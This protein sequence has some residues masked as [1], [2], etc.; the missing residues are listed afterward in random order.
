MARNPFEQLQ[1]VVPEPRQ[2]FEDIAALILRAT[3]SGSRRVRV[4]KGDGGVDTYTGTYGEDGHADVYQIKYFPSVWDESRK[5]QIRESYRTARDNNDFNLGTWTLCVPTRLTKG[6]LR[7]FDEWKTKQDRSIELL[8]GD[9]ITERL[10]REECGQARQL[11]RS[12]GLI[13]LA[14]GG[15]RIGARAIFRHEN[16][17]RS[18]LTAVLV[19]QLRN[20][21]DR[22]ARNLKLIVTHGETGCL[23]HQATADWRQAIN[24]GCV[25]PRRLYYI[26]TL[27]PG[28]RSVVMGI[29]VCDRTE[30]PLA[31]SLNITAEDSI[32]SELTCLVDGS[33]LTT[34]A[35]VEFGTS[36]SLISTIAK[37]TPPRVA[38][39]NPPTSPAA[40]DLLETILAH[41]TPEER[42]LTQ[43]LRQWPGGVSDQGFIPNTT[44][45]GSA[46][47]MKKQVLQTAIAELVQLGWL[48]KPEGDDNVRVYA[49]VTDEGLQPSLR[50]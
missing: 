33:N 18:G 3:V 27:N 38:Q 6:D 12:W 22:S 11:L 41:P 10:Q 36:K 5:Q 37:S 34:G 2:A 16:P 43:I 29:P 7:W 44:E 13:G 1:D 31:I 23:A 35:H 42:G 26:H 9:D 39:R 46:F 19:I 8:D 24:D 4:H 14:I 32:P 50:S 17:E 21:G 48:G 45:G 15:S 30:Y 49:L 40:K 20:D 28:D 47:G 25:N